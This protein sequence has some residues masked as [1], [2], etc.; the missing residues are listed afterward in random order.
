MAASGRIA[1][2]IGLE[3]GYMIEDDLRVLRNF[4]RL[5]VRYMTLTHSFNTRLGRLVGNRQAGSPRHDGL[6]SVRA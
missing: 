3:G 1:L 5:G 4:Y 6:K 2:L